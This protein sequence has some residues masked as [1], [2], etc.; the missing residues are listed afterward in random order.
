MAGKIVEVVREQRDGKPVVRLELENGDIINA[1]PEFD[2]KYT[3]VAGGYYVV[4]A[5]GVKMYLPAD[6]FEAQYK[7]L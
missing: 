2:E 1:G 6:Q 7:K 3:P 5:D 4:W